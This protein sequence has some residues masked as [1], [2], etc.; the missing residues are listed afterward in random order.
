MM[1]LKKT[2]LTPAPSAQILVQNATS[3]VDVRLTMSHFEHLKGFAV[4]VIRRTRSIKSFSTPCAQYCFF[5]I[6]YVVFWGGVTSS[7][8]FNTLQQDSVT[9]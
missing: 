5:V 7:A 2:H 3:S 1:L 4:C 6:M 8:F 9:A